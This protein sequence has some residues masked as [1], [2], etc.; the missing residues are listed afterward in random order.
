MRAE[1]EIAGEASNQPSGQ[2]N[3]LGA[4]D[5]DTTDAALRGRCGI[6]AGLSMRT[7]GSTRLGD[8]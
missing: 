5:A 7:I 6:A 8:S 3:H 1:H 2:L 4:L